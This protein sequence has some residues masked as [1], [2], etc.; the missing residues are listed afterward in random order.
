MRARIEAVSLSLA[1]S[2]YLSLSLSPTLSLPLS[3]PLA[4]SLPLS[5]SYTHTWRMR[6]RIEAIAKNPTLSATP[7]LPN[8]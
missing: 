2:L 8:R 5:L 4:R 3:H 1:V 6:A 7:P